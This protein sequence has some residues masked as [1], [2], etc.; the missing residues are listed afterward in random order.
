MHRLRKH[1]WL[2]LALGLAVVAVPLVLRALNGRRRPADLPGVTNSVGM[3][4]V[5]LPP[6]KFAMGSPDDEEGRDADEGP[7]HEVEIC[8]PFYLG[9]L[10]VT[11]EQYQRVVGVNPSAFP[12]EGPQARAGFP[13]HNVSWDDAVTFCKRLSELPEERAAGRSY[14]LPTEAEWEYACRAGTTGLFGIEHVHPRAFCL[15]NEPPAKGDP[16]ARRALGPRPAEGHRRP[17]PWGLYDMHGNVREWCADRYA[18]DYYARSPAAD[19]QGPDL[20]GRRVARGGSWGDDVVACR[21]AGRTGLPPGVRLGNGLRVVM[22]E[23]GAP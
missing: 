1:P 21:S 8:R 17:N 10:E 7:R 3:R 19:P 12:G 18:A 6:G 11:E 16:E 9:A 5:Q 15:F 20:S 22:V 14:R 4:L 23:G 13:V 2:L